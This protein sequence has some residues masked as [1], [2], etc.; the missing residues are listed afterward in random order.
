MPDR[1]SRPIPTSNPYEPWPGHA[2]L[3]FPPPMRVLAARPGAKDTRPGEDDY[4]CWSC[5]YA[6]FYGSEAL[7]KQAVRQRRAEIKRREKLKARAREVAMG[8]RPYRPGGDDD[9]DYDD[10]EEEEDDDEDECEGRCSC[11]RALPKCE[12]DKPPD[13]DG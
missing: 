1:P 2:A 6:L 5:Q 3:L 10:E 13:K 7:R 4:I 11:G 9:D 12:E 8:T